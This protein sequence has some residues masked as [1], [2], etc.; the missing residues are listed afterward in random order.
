MNL[1]LRYSQTNKTYKLLSKKHT[2]FYK[3]RNALVIPAV[4]QVSV[5]DGNRLDSGDPPAHLQGVKDPIKI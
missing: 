2:L 5:N 1:H 3:T 4:L